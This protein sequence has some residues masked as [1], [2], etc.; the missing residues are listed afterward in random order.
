MTLSDGN[1]SVEINGIEVEL[2]VRGRGKPLLFLH[3]EIG[4]DRAGAALDR[5]AEGARV[6]APTHPGFGRAKAPPGFNSVDDIA[7]LYLDLLDK[8]DLRDVAVVGPGLGG[9]I[10]AEIA[11]KTTTR[12][13]HLVLVDAFG[14]KHGDRDARDIYDMYFITDAEL[15]KVLYFDQAVANRDLTKLPDEELYAI[16]RAREATSL[17]GWRPYMHDPKLKGRLHRIGIPALVL[18]GA[19]DRIVGPDYGRA[20]SA[21]LPR[22]RFAEI[23]R[24][25]HFPHVERPDEFARHVLDFIAGKES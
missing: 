17:Y 14:V 11:V 3:P 15:Q 12:L 25:G 1:S 4:F 10:G 20:Y 9:W 13:S 16:A 24:A 2:T 5:L 19:E 18:W 7:Y 23:E 8:L 22:A 21:A 6:I